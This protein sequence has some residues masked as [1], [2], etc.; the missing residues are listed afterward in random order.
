MILKH[1]RYSSALW[2]K[3]ASL[4]D[5]T[6]VGT[7]RHAKGRRH[8]HSR[9]KRTSPN[10]ANQRQKV[11]NTMG[12]PTA[13]KAGVAFGVDLDLERPCTPSG[14]RQPSR[15]VAL[16]KHESRTVTP[17]ML[18]NKQRKA[19]ERR[20]AYE[21]ARLERIR[22]RQD[23]CRR[24]NQTVEC[25]LK[26]DAKR[27]GNQDMMN[28]EPMSRREASHAIHKVSRHLTQ[29]GLQMKSDFSTP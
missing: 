29:F 4:T 6:E 18:T 13:K 10:L 27:H 14:G 9:A 24:L 16:Q 26:Q 3:R 12:E 15:L 23:E 28:V 8:S 7:C 17:A 1:S 25:L 21:V 20:K 22:R 11:L 5:T 19:E 2:A